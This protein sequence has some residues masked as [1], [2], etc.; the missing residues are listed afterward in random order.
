[1][2]DSETYVEIAAASVDNFIA[3]LGEGG[4]LED[5][6]TAR[7]MD[8]APDLQSTPRSPRPERGDRLERP[9]RQDRAE[10]PAPRP[11]E[12]RAERPTGPKPKWDKPKGER[13]ASDKPKPRDDG[14]V[15]PYEKRTAPAAREDRPKRADAPAKYDRKSARGCAE[16]QRVQGQAGKL[17]F[18]QTGG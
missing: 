15:K 14:A 10:R 2:Q 5:G 13:A 8:S 11:R 17:V 18:Q 16:I 7:V 1:M 6:V 9:A 12:D 4:T 3:G